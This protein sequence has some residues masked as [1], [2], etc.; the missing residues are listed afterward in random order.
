M[1]MTIIRINQ[2]DRFRNELEYVEDIP[3]LLTKYTK[4]NFNADLKI[5][6]FISHYEACTSNSHSAPIN[7]KTNWG[8][9]R[10]DYPR[11]FPGFSGVIEGKIKGKKT[12]IRSSVQWYVRKE[13]CFS[14]M[15]NGWFIGPA[16]R[17]AAFH[18]GTG[19]GLE[20]FQYAWNIF[21]EDYPKLQSKYDEYLKNIC[22]GF[23]EEKAKEIQKNINKQIS[24][25]YIPDFRTWLEEEKRREGK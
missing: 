9:N 10:K 21:I 25:F 14:D 15:F 13:I 20:D 12:E 8:I 4:E 11:G 7:K 5:N 3:Q 1:N 18:T 23:G 24:R 6:R 16:I 17:I 19:G 2:D 22:G